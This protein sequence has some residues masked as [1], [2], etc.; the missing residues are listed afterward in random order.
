MVGEEQSQ[1]GFRGA[2]YWISTAGRMVEKREGPREDGNCTEDARGK[3][4]PGG[5][6]SMHS[7]GE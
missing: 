5:K 7:K 1:L 3:P 4:S 2:G 6:A